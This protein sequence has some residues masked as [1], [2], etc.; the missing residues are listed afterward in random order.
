[1]F[2]YHFGVAFTVFKFVMFYNKY[3]LI[4]YKKNTKF[5]AIKH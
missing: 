3:I 5:N 4:S 1:M 2:D